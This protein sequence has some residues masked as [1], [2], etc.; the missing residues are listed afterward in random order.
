MKA[1]LVEAVALGR[2]AG[3]SGDDLCSVGVVC[4]GDCYDV[5]DGLVFSLPAQYQDG[6]WKPVLG[7]AGSDGIKAMLWCIDCVFNE[8]ISTGG[9]IEASQDSERTAGQCFRET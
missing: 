7:L 8:Y 5:P 3:H 4:N 6:C 2:L 1:S 9:D